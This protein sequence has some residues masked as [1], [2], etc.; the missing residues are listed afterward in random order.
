MVFTVVAG[1]R[2]G[3]DFIGRVIQSIRKKCRQLF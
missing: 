2:G 1:V 3:N